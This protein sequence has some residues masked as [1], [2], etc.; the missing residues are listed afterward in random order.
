M[1]LGDYFTEEEYLGNRQ[2]RYQRTFPETLLE[3]DA[4][5][6]LSLDPNKLA[7]M[8]HPRC[9]GSESAISCSL[10]AGPPTLSPGGKNGRSC[11]KTVWAPMEFPRSRHEQGTSKLKNQKRHHHSRSNTRRKYCDHDDDICSI[12]DDG[13]SAELS[14]PD[15]DG[16]VDVRPP[17]IVVHYVWEGKIFVTKAWKAENLF[18]T[19]PFVIPGWT[20]ESILRKNDYADVYSVSPI[21][22]CNMPLD[23]RANFEAH[24]FLEYHLHNSRLYAKRQKR[25]MRASGLCLESLWCNRRNVLIMRSPLPHEVSELLFIE[26][27]FPPLV[28]KESPNSTQ[29][30]A[31]RAHNFSN[32]R[33]YAAI[34]GDPQLKQVSIQQPPLSMQ[35]S[36][37]VVKISSTPGVATIEEPCLKK[38]ER[39][40]NRRRARRAADG[41]NFF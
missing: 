27:D 9:H 32:K 23:G 34:V 11:R 6:R 31:P 16:C 7:A 5:R 33:S 12:Q 8:E 40:R 25:R 37:G 17:T 30:V 24:V 38:S 3:R 26:T 13:D 29:D 39:Q 1:I 15:T 10:Q 18:P 21:D 4:K 41:M 35:R 22:T 2:V 14:K 20:V 28:W 19:R 36:A